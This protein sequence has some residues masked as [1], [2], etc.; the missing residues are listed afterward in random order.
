[1]MVRVT[2]MTIMVVHH[3]DYVFVFVC[4]EGEEEPGLHAIVGKGRVIQSCLD[5]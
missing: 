1:M 2:M 3:L 5:S 4:V